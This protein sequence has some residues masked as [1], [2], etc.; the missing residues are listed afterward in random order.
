LGIEHAVVAFGAQAA[1][2]AADLPPYTGVPPA[3]APL[4][5]PQGMDAAHKRVQAGD[6]GKRGFAQPM[7]FGLRQM[8]RQIGKG[9]Q[10]VDQIAHAGQADEQD[11][12]AVSFRL[13]GGKGRDYI[14]NARA[15]CSA[16]G[17]RYTRAC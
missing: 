8:A 13:R 15:A 10:G 4:P 14:A 1:F 7:Q 16:F 5:Q 3:F 11:F 6:V 9:R 12:H 17:R 2:Q